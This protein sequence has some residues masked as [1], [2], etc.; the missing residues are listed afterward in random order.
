MLKGLAWLFMMSF[1]ADSSSITRA[2]V[3]GFL[4]TN[5]RDM[6]VEGWHIAVWSALFF[7]ADIANKVGKDTK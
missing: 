7:L 3:D 4:G 5:L 1:I 6:P 2:F